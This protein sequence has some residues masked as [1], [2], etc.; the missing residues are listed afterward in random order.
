MKRNLDSAQD[1]INN[2]YREAWR[3]TEK[4]KEIFQNLISLF[5]FQLDVSIIPKVYLC[6]VDR[7]ND[8]IRKEHGVPCGGGCYKSNPNPKIFIR[9][10]WGGYD[11]LLHEL[12]HHIDDLNDSKPINKIMN[13]WHRQSFM[14]K[15]GYGKLLRKAGIPTKKMR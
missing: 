11:T 2:Y 8:C 15:K 3:A 12:Y 9:D 1:K 10:V 13:G 5:C 6:D 4:R 14:I 7:Q